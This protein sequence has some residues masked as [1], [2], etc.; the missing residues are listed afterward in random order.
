VLDRGR[1]EYDEGEDS[2][3]WKPGKVTRV[4]DSD[5]ELAHDQPWYEYVT[6][7][8]RLDTGFKWYHNGKTRFGDQ[9]WGLS[10]DKVWLKP[11]D[12]PDVGLSTGLPIEDLDAEVVGLRR[13]VAELE[14]ATTRGASCCK[15]EEASCEAGHE[16]DSRAGT[17]G[18][19]VDSSGE[20]A[21]SPSDESSGDEG[22]SDEGSSDEGSSDEGSSDESSDGEWSDDLAR[23]AI[24]AKIAA[25]DSLILAAQAEHRDIQQRQQQQQQQW[26][27]QQPQ[28]QQPALYQQLVLLIGKIYSSSADVASS[29]SAGFD[30]ESELVQYRQ[31]MTQ[32]PKNSDLENSDFS[33]HVSSANLGALPEIAVTHPPDTFCAVYGRA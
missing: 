27:Q 4:C 20:E 32:S 17:E 33:Y 19:S 8:V 1:G 9:T 7:E 10:W 5:E 25:N 14:S 2:E 23:A 13:R 3:I 28:Q 16:D 21:E 11:D 15:D 30:F 31:R 24:D 26:V 29:S 18:E 12:A 22:S 6:Y